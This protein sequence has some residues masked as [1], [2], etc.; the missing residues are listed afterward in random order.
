M[1]MKKIIIFFA[2]IITCGFINAQCSIEKYTDTDGSLGYHAAA[3][4]LIRLVGSNNN[5]DMGEGFQKA[6]GFLACSGLNKSKWSLFIG[7]A[8]HGI[9]SR[10]IP[11]QITFIFT[12]ETSLVLSASTYE[13][14]GTADKC[15]FDLTYTDIIYF[16]KSISKIIV[17]DTRTGASFS[18]TPKYANVLVE[19]YDCLKK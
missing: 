18:G 6:Y 19:Q 5:G 9:Y 12:D 4:D 11:R 1:S 16:T 17:T 13:N 10:I 3:E 2:L 7:S 14:L 15:I 8:S